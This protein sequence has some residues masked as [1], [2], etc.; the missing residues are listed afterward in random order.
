VEKAKSSLSIEDS[1]R[2]VKFYEST[3]SNYS[4]APL[5]QNFGVSLVELVRKLESAGQREEIPELL[6]KVRCLER[7][8]VSFDVEG[9]SKADRALETALTVQQIASQDD[10][11]LA[12]TAMNWAAVAR[13]QN[14]PQE[15]VRKEQTFL[16]VFVFFCL[17]LCRSVV[18]VWRGLFQNA[19]T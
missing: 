10:A 15:M 3:L 4:S 9:I 2:A 7:R 5:L 17:V 8:K 11:A 16:I 14:K 12:E 13:F 18:F 1:R 6:E 19:R